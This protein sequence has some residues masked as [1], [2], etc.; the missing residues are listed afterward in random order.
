VGRQNKKA[1]VGAMKKSP[2]NILR[3]TWIDKNDWTQI[4]FKRY[5]RFESKP[6]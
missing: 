4:L 2:K 3:M 5:L 1:M 6:R